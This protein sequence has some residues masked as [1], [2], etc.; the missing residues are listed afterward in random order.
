M[1]GGRN[2]LLSEAAAR[3]FSCT[4]K[5]H[6]Y[7]DPK[8]FSTFRTSCRVRLAV[9][10]WTY[11]KPVVQWGLMP[12]IFYMGMRIEPRSKLKDFWPPF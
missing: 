8:S 5:R 7:N 11:A 12:T 10:V 4:E 9:Q 3:V 2:S 1:P 6:A